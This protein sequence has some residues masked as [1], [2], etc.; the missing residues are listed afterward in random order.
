MHVN[1]DRQ[2]YFGHA[3][4]SFEMSSVNFIAK[5][6]EADIENV[7]ELGE[8]PFAATPLTPVTGRNFAP[9]PIDLVRRI[10]S[11]ELSK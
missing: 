11:K 7:D 6:I 3:L 10:K 9:L 5:S 1:K 4:L 2:Q 8:K